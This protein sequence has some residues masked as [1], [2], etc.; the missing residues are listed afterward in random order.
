VL[1]GYLSELAHLVKSGMHVE[2]ILI[3]KVSRILFQNEGT[4]IFVFLPHGRG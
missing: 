3:C 4:R 2:D 1:L